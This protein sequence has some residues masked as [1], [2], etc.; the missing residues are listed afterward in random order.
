MNRKVSI[1]VPVYNVSLYIKRCLNSIVAQTYKNIEVIFVDDCGVDDSIAKV[2]DFIKSTDI[3]CKILRHAK[4][5]GL[6]AAR[7]TGLEAVTGEYVYFLDSDDEIT[8]NCIEL[9]VAALNQFEYDIVCGNYSAIGGE[10]QC[11]LRVGKGPIIGNATILNT[12][13]ENKWY[14][15]AVNKLYRY[16][17]IQAHSLRFKEGIIHEDELCSF[18]VSL[19]AESL[20]VETKRT[21]NY[22]INPG[23]IMTN[24]NL[25]R[26][27]C[28]WATILL[29]MS[30]C[31]RNQG[32]YVDD[33][34][35]N[36]IETLK[37]NITCEAYRF[38]DRNDFRHYYNILGKGEWRPI[39]EFM[40]KRLPFKRLLKDLCFYFPNYVGFCYLCL[41]YKLTLRPLE[42]TM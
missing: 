13:L 39:K 9:L 35:Y 24:L 26:H 31:A 25:I 42:T 14:A 40:N 21:Y 29:D 8:D 7:N 12:F 20:Y 10:V 15:M 38:L 41:W 27:F 28:S 36:Y 3:D 19:C 18:A 37:T 16:Q 6:S 22:Y 17:F 5:L 32:K 1:I 33:A 30:S 23:S 34:V 4:N 11:E 2:E